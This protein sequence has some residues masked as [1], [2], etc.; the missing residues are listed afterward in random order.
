MEFIPA[1]TGIQLEFLQYGTSL[2]HNLLNQGSS[3][4]ILMTSAIEIECQC[5]SK[6]KA[7]ADLI[8]DV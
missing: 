6:L 8:W 7:S 2:Y 5:R 4:E 3:I 1:F